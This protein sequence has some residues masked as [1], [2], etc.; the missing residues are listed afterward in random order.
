MRDSD[1]L[2]KEGARDDNAPKLLPAPAFAG[3][4]AGSCILPGYLA[5]SAGIPTPSGGANLVAPSGGAKL[6]ST[7]A[8]LAT[9]GTD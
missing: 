6:M 7:G 9:A 5:P 4:G 2:A 8:G 3:L 1:G